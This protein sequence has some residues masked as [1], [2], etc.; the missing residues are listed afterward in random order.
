MKKWMLLP[1]ILMC[2][3]AQAQI[4]F[5][6]FQ[7]VLNY[8]DQH[9]IAIQSA[10]INEEVAFAEKKE[11]QT[12]LLPSFSSSLG[13][14]DNIAL[15]PVLLPSQVFDPS[16]PEDSFE[17]LTFGTKY[18]YS[19]GF[20]VQW[21]ILNFQKIFALKTAKIGLEESKLNT[22]INR[23]NTYN[24][25]ASTYYSVLLSKESI[26]IYE[27]NLK[28][29]ESIYEL[30]QEKYTK[31]I[32]SEAEL[33]RAQINQ[34]QNQRILEAAKNNLD[35]FYVQL[36]SQLNT[37]K[38]ISIS[39]TPGQ[40][41]VHDTAN[42]MIHPEVVLQEAAVKKYEIL[43][44]QQKAMRFPSLSLFYQNN[45]SWATNDFL[46]FSNA[47]E[48]PQEYFGISLSISLFNFSTRPKIK[49]SKSQLRIQQQQLE[50]T[51]LVTKKEDDLLE[52]QLNQAADQ[53][54][55]NQQILRLQEQ[56]DIHSENQYQSG[57]MSLDIR[58]DKYDDLLIAQD[59]Y[60]QSLAEFT[61]AQYKI[62][63]RQIDFQ[64]TSRS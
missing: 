34:L 46:D 30:A 28:V 13:Y 9:S 20:A 21:D 10:I 2:F 23:Y 31:G 63:I 29:S 44:K 3:S 58:L 64:S 52:L 57:I 37:D 53:L 35:Q 41:I 47:T 11:A 7:D 1:L 45:T 40:L 33:N 26:Q 59:N 5:S 42:F 36:Q 6:S 22:D 48:L 19:R 17:Q 49:Q 60:L 16:A 27:E 39:D 50:N 51:K 18:Q 38:T 61:L 43:V 62:F 14:N 25:L 55:K 24:Q 8:A 4:Q 15:Q 12:Y 56:N 54:S 32:I